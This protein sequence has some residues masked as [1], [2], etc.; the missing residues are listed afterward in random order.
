MENRVQSFYQQELE[1]VESLLS[2]AK[3]P[4]VHSTRPGQVSAASPHGN[5]SM[6][7]ALQ[8]KD[9]GGHDWGMKTHRVSP[10]NRGY[11][12]SLLERS[13]NT[14]NLKG[15][16]TC[17]F[18]VLNLIK[19]NLWVEKKRSLRFVV[20]STPWDG[21]LI[22]IGAE[23]GRN[24]WEE[25]IIHPRLFIDQQDDS[26]TWTKDFNDLLS[27]LQKKVNLLCFRSLN[28]DQVVF[29]LVYK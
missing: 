2:L 12:E 16:W 11:V 7:P 28:K 23:W 13:L 15:E 8:P 20:L 29:S 25:L 19:L 22:S 24:R 3:Q 17:P 14:E 18:P 9:V 4:V 26:C 6:A 5:E 10:G 21:R 27:L 1:T